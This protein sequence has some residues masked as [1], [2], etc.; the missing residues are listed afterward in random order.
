MVVP[1]LVAKTSFISYIPD[2]LKAL[3]SCAWVVLAGLAFWKFYGSLK[4]A[5]DSQNFSFEIGGFKLSFQE[6]AKGLTKQ[7]SDLQSRV[8]QLENSL[9]KQNVVIEGPSSGLAEKP[10]DLE[11]LQSDREAEVESTEDTPTPALALHVLW[12]DDNPKR[13]AY[14]IGTIQS[15]GG[16][17]DT[18]SFTRDGLAKFEG[19]RYDAV[20]A[21]ADGGRR[22][23]IEFIKAI[24]GEEK[25]IPILVYTSSLHAASMRKEVERIG[26]D[27][28]T[29]SAVELFKLLRY[30]PGS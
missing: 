20:I 16:T 24:R 27:G 9:A 15:E 12:V 1:E 7:I 13:N 5:I 21:V 29:S 14:E 30:P 18:A 26:A 2:F 10:E 11:A 6:T 23:G 19:S 25:A 28:I 8:I 4:A 22:E 17:V 3:V